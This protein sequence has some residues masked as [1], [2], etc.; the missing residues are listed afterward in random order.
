MRKIMA[1]VSNWMKRL[2]GNTKTEAPETGAIRSWESIAG[3]EP[4]QT[5]CKDMRQALA[6]D[7]GAKSWALAGRA[8]ILVNEGE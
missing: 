3:S 6:G 4:I 8:G 5:W 7:G 2:F 1:N